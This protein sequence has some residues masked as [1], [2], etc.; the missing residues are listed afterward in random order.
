M[1]ELLQMELQFNSDST[2]HIQQVSPTCPK[3]IVSSR[4]S[5]LLECVFVYSESKSD[6]RYFKERIV[7]YLKGKD[8]P[9]LTK[10]MWNA[11]WVRNDKGLRSKY[12]Y[13]NEYNQ[14]LY[15]DKDFWEW[16]KL[17]CQLAD[18]ELKKIINNE[19]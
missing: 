8:E 15:L 19:H 1:K 6:E 3:P 5:V 9:T 14:R 2:A 12:L 18:C 16:C 4:L 13:F 7:N 10:T 17:Y 11:C